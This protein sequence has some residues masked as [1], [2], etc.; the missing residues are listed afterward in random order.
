MPRLFSR[1]GLI[2]GFYGDSLLRVRTLRN[3]GGQQ[4]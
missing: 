3:T 1:D 4:E 2:E